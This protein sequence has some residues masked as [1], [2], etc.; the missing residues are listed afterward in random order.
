MVTAMPAPMHNTSGRIRAC[1]GSS[2]P[3]RFEVLVSPARPRTIFTA[4]ESL[5]SQGAGFLNMCHDYMHT[6]C[7]TLRRRRLAAQPAIVIYHRVSTRSWKAPTSRTSCGQ[8][9][10]WTRSS[11]S[12]ASTDCWMARRCCLTPSETVLTQSSCDFGPRVGSPFGCPAPCR[13]FLTKGSRAGFLD[14]RSRQH[15]ST[16]RRSASPFPSKEMIMAHQP[17]WTVTYNHEVL[18]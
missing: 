14:S 12:E 1:E 7:D 16:L 3:A 18:F 8:E 10:A 5:P 2:L 17:T 6:S 11:P 13:P 4:N 15:W 9:A